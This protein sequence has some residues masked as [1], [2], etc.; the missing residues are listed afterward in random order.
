MKKTAILINTSRGPVIDE[1]ALVEALKAGEIAGAGL[2]VYENEPKFEP[3][4]AKLKNVVMVPHIASATI[5]TRS[6]MAEMAAGN[7][8]AA[9]KGEMPPNCVNPEVLKK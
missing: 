3:D 6:R 9:L 1:K 5:D 4:L 7:L 8:V 2:D